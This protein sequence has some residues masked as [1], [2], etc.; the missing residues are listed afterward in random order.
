MGEQGREAKRQIQGRRRTKEGQGGQGRGGR[1]G[2][3]G[4]NRELEKML[5]HKS[6]GRMVRA[7]L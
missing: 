5:I 7:G 6:A 1:G 2:R 3:M 4:E